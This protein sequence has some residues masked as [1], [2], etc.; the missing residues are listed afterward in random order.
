MINKLYN[1]KKMQTEQKLMEKGLISSKI[2]QIDI[3][4]LLTQNSIDN[5]RVQKFGA[6]S[7]FTILTIHK[8]TMKEHIKEL[9]SQKNILNIQLEI[10]VKEIIE[11]QKESEQFKYILDEE[12]KEKL[13][14]KVRIEN[15]A[16]EEF[17]QSKYIKNQG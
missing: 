14:E 3:E 11:Y 1:L 7:D 12:R 16:M 6:I 5:A 10:L 2:E 8:N 17:I 13:M 15:E 9:E 4:I